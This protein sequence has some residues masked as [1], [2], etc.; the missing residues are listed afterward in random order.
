[1]D[2]ATAVKLLPQVRSV[3]SDM[4]TKASHTSWQDESHPSTLAEEACAPVVPDSNG[5]ADSATNSA[6]DGA[7]NCAP[8]N[9]ADDACDQ[10][11][12]RWLQCWTLCLPRPK[13]QEREIAVRG[14]EGALHRITVLE[15]ATIGELI[16]LAL[17]QDGQW[18]PKKRS[19]KGRLLSLEGR[20]FDSG[21]RVAEL[22]L[23]AEL[24]L[25]I[26]S[27][28]A[29]ACTKCDCSLAGPCKACQEQCSTVL[30]S[31]PLVHYSSN[32]ESIPASSTTSES[33]IV[34]Q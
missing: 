7:A 28:T 33:V 17:I 34:P 1:M 22:P 3:S 30:T 20:K 16:L 4:S 31:A 29:A 18:P 8:D 27:N 10:R 11:R 19:D 2:A 13:P 23:G 24:R 15:D 25:A 9:V 26:R 14:I 12:P 21:M 5:A 6:A 32:H